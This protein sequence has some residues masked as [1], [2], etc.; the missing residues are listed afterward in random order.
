MGGRGSSDQ[1][2]SLVYISTTREHKLALLP[3][4]SGRV[5]AEVVRI[6]RGTRFQ[7]GY[8]WSYRD[9]RD[10]SRLRPSAACAS[11]T[12]DQSLVGKLGRSE[13]AWSRGSR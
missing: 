8:G 7:S 12:A 10:A 4:V 11:T 2:G 9:R 13:I 6:V 5:G 1:K 3:K